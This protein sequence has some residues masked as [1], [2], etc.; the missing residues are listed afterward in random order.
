MKSKSGWNFS[1]KVWLIRKWFSIAIAYLIEIFWAGSGWSGWVAGGTVWVNGQS[2]LTPEVMS[3][4]S[5]FR[6]QESETDRVFLFPGRVWLICE[7]IS[8]RGWGVDWKFLSMVWLFFFKQSLVKKIKSKSGWNF[9]LCR[10]DLL[11]KRNWV[12]KRP[13]DLRYGVSLQCYASNE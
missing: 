1:S 3:D 13:K 2:G 4:F 10:N 7:R 6:F 5:P 11:T 9:L 12:K 8:S